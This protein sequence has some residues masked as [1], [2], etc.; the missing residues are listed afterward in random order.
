MGGLL[1][2]RFELLSDLHGEDVALAGSPGTVAV[3]A[4]LALE[5]PVTQGRALVQQTQMTLVSKET[6]VPSKIQLRLPLLQL[7]MTHNKDS[8]FQSAGYSNLVKLN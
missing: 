7:A 6:G 4:A 2:P 3:L 1:R 5:H 8:E